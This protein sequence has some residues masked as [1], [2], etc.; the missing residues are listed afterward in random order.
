MVVREIT[1]SDTD[2]IVQAG[3]EMLINST[4]TQT[5]NQSL[6][7][8]H[9]NHRHSDSP[10]Q[11]VWTWDNSTK[12]GSESEILLVHLKNSCDMISKTFVNDEITLWLIH[13]YPHK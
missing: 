13:L 6:T 9:S 8:H 12:G 11:V 2:L 1:Q 4:E 10:L 7:P 3:Q 5:S